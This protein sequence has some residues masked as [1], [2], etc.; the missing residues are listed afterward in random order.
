M[1]KWY[2][3]NSI[4]SKQNVLYGLCVYS[5]NISYMFQPSEVLMK[6]ILKE[7]LLV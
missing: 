6:S 7:N 5:N 3:K 2:S 4:I 1:F